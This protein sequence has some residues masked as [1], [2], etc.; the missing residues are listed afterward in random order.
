MTTGEEIV[1][2]IENNLLNLK[3]RNQPIGRQITQC[4]DHEQEYYRLFQSYLY[5]AIN[6]TH[7]IKCAG[8]RNDISPFKDFL[9]KRSIIETKI[10]Q[11][12]NLCIINFT[13][14][15]N[16]VEKF[17]NTNISNEWRQYIIEDIDNIIK[18]VKENPDIA[19]YEDIL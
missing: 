6:G 13:K 15:E 12:K 1:K 4:G 7:D 16:V 5:G 14:N 3:V 2:K 10:N 17:L 18:I 11:Y 9:T 8:I 19:T